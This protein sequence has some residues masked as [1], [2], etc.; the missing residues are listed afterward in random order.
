MAFSLALLG[1]LVVALTVSSASPDYQNMPEPPDNPFATATPTPYPSQGASGSGDDADTLSDEELAA[2][3]KR[4]FGAHSQNDDAQQG[5]SGQSGCPVKSSELSAVEFEDHSFT[6]GYGIFYGASDYRRLKSDY[7]VTV[8]GPSSVNVTI[9]YGPGHAS[10]TRSANRRGPLYDDDG[11]YVWAAYHAYDTGFRTAPRPVSGRIA[12]NKSVS[13]TV[14]GCSDSGGSAVIGSHT[15][16]YST[17]TP[18]PTPDPNPPARPTGLTAS[19]GSTSMS[20][21]WDA[22]PNADSYQVYQTVKDGDSGFLPYNDYT[23]SIRGSSAV[24]GNLTENKVY[25]YHVLSRKDNGLYSEWSDHVIATTTSS[26]PTPTATNTPVPTAT[27]TPRPTATHTPTATATRT[28]TPTASPTRT[29]THTPTP[30]VV[31]TRTATYTPTPTATV[32]PTPAPVPDTPTATPPP[33][34]D[35]PTATPTLTPSDTPVPTPVSELQIHAKI[36]RID[37]VST[38]KMRNR[39]ITSNLMS[40]RNYWDVLQ[41]LQI[42]IEINGPDGVDVDEYEFQITAPSTSG[43]YI[44]SECDYDSSLPS[45]DTAPYRTSAASFFLVRCERGDG[46][47]EITIESRHKATG[48]NVNN[49]LRRLE[50]PKAR[51]HGDKTVSYRFCGVLPP[52]S[53]PPDPELDYDRAFSLGSGE[54]N[55]ESTGMSIGRLHSG[56]CY[57]S[58]RVAVSFVT[59]YPCGN[60]EFLGCIRTPFITDLDSGI[61]RMEIDVELP[62]G[63]IWTSNHMI[64]RDDIVRYLP[65][66]ISHELGHAAGLGHSALTTDLMY[67]KY[68]TNVIA[69][70]SNDVKAMRKVYR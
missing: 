68:S 57:L 44:G 53:M 41:S 63:Q 2:I 38:E 55:K 69:P 61:L 18:T 4:L 28:P 13:I 31:P 39:R 27:Y 12:S 70:S 20:L 6:F 42:R 51:R 36:T 1:S 40:Y 7:T 3:G 60:S 33:V 22:A 16:D 25:A 58:D 65:A 30:T 23:I 50:I 17:P 54:W 66:V 5:A 46:K 59:G 10:Q 64:R 45:T 9:D 47:S 62:T 34:S 43:V 14:S 48:V 8:G 32:T 49:S 67:E 56:S 29:A 21:E 26:S 15:A 37:G 52:P 19:P 24:V 35:T 11:S